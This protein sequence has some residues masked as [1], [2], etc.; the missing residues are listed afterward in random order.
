MRKTVKLLYADIIVSLMLAGGLVVRSILLGKPLGAITLPVLIFLVVNAL[1]C[2]L[3]AWGIRRGR[4]KTAVGVWIF[5]LSL[6]VFYLTLD[7]LGGYLFI[8]GREITTTRLPDEYAH[9]KYAPSKTQRAYDPADFDVSVRINNMGFRGRDVGEKK[10]PGAYRIV[11]L[12][13]SFTFGAGVGDDQTFSSVLEKILNAS[14]PG[15]YEVVNCGVESFSPVL[16]Y[17]QLK[18]NIDRLKPD[19]VIMNFDMSDLMNELVYRKEAS[20]GGDGEP[21]AVSGMEDYRRSREGTMRRLRSWVYENLF[22]TT[23][24]IETIGKRFRGDTGI[25]D[26]NVETGIER[27]WMMM[28]IH[29]LKN[30][31]QPENSAE[32]YG[33][34]EDSILR[35]KKLCEAE[36]CVFVLTTYPWGHQVSDDEWK[37]GRYEWLPRETNLSNIS[38]RTVEELD[39]FAARNEIPFLNTFPAFRNYRGSGR[40]YYTH[41]IHWT[42][43]GHRLMAE[44]LASFIEARTGAAI[45][46]ALKCRMIGVFIDQDNCK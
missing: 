33:M 27:E 10:D 9:H 2:A 1:F 15:K 26:V 34:V 7:L 17:I 6:I 36:G 32:M 30:F 35:T 43:A 5:C 44:T 28:L 38:D 12:G 31:P 16:E 29:T 11:M 20:L 24:L 13:D 8:P 18:R 42:P 39:R 22:I 46:S 40:L 21:L 41:D 45:D 23:A 25:E 4:G 3:S 37:P 14:S 19:M